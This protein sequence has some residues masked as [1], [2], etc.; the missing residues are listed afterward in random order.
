MN[1]HK[2]ALI[3]VLKNKLSSSQVK[4]SKMSSQCNALK[5]QNGGLIK[6]SHKTNEKFCHHHHQQY[7]YE[8]E[9]NECAICFEKLDT[10][11][12][13]PLECGHWFH[14]N[15]L[16]Q[17]KKHSCPMCR[18]NFTESE[19]GYITAS[20]MDKFNQIIKLLQQNPSI[21]ISSVD[22]RNLN[23]QIPED[24]NFELF[25]HSHVVQRSQDLKIRGSLL[26]AFKSE[27]LNFMKFFHFINENLKNSERTSKLN[28]ILNLKIQKLLVAS[29]S[30]VQRY[31][32]E[33]HGY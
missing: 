20:P 25:L 8:S 21:N 1:I 5:I 33:I 27:H 14:K 3:S 22:L 10:R 30:K 26:N 12:D 4:F 29:T 18:T 31:N 17:T 13:I 6:C 32:P 24:R 15:C 28:Q 7:R 16:L 19:I 23:I 11:V 9:T 2:Q